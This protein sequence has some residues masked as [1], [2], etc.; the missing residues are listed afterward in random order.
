MQ[1]RSREQISALADGEV[2]GP[3]F[4]RVVDGLRNAEQ[5]QAWERYHL[6]RDTLRGQLPESLPAGFAD[7][8]KERIAAEPPHHVRVA[9]VLRFPRDYWRQ[10]AGMALA[11][12]VTAA[13]ILGIQAWN[14]SVVEE[15]S[16][17]V[18]KLAQAGPPSTPEPATPDP[19]LTGYMVR[20]NEYSAPTGMPGVLPYARVVSHR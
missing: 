19:K 3:E 13:T 14:T 1:D 18:P 16:A 6:I 12:S 15:P 5:L 4:G 10:A 20:H 7:R 17:S 9:P 2:T 8:V 11:A